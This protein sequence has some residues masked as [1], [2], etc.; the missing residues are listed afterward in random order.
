MDLTLE[1]LDDISRVLFAGANYTGGSLPA[2]QLIPYLEWYWLASHHKLPPLRAQSAGLIAIQSAMNTG[3]AFSLADQ[4]RAGFIRVRRASADHENP[5]WLAFLERFRRY[6]REAGLTAGF[7][8]QLAGVAVEMEQNIHD[9]SG[10]ASSG[11]VAFLSHK[12]VFEFVVLDFGSGV[13]DSLRTNEEFTNLSD[14]NA[15]LLCAVGVRNSRYGTMT[16]RGF[17]FVDLMGAIANSRALIR[18][19]SG[20][21]LLAMDGTGTDRIPFEKAQ[22]AVGQGF[23]IAV[24]VHTRANVPQL[25]AAL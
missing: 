21:G 9:H 20:D 13:L 15:A 23:M 3:L 4:P 2:T 8:D 17:G 7:S 5:G 1:A 6:G 14:H 12:D 25:F 22:R 11:V 18:L 10:H 19:R 16:G 24:R